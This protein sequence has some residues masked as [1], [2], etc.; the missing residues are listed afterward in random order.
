MSQGYIFSNK[1]SGDA[2]VKNGSY[3]QIGRVKSI[4]LGPYI[5]GTSIADEN[6]QSS[7]DIGKITYELL[8]SPLGTS[9]S[10]GVSN[11]AYPIFGF[12]KQY[13]LLGEVVL[14][15]TGPS[16]SLNDK[17]TDQ[18]RYYFPSYALWGDTHHNAFPNLSELSKY[19]SD[20]GGKAPGYAKSENVD[21]LKFP[22][23]NVFVEKN[24]V[25]TLKPFEGDTVIQSRFG[26]SIRFG[27]TST[28]EKNLNTWSNSGE[29]GDPI[30]II[31]NQMGD[32]NEIS[33]FDGTVEN[34]NRDGSAIYM[35]STQEIFL[36][37]INSFPLNSF[38]KSVDPIVQPLYTT[39]RIPTSN[40][41]ISAAT[42][43]ENSLGES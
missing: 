2:S 43:D 32:R 36:E 24:S 29:T 21:N 5:S 31:L 13:P 42:Q 16:P 38:G 34:I 27:S 28:K 14:I 20:Y 17:S 37:D 39:T 26:Q 33:K 9:L 23:G 30:T 10:D 6:Y 18:R 4:V 15:I 41:G 11:P 7:A 19:L 22:L 12:I 8:Y 3:F 25:R 35:T 1:L 40:F